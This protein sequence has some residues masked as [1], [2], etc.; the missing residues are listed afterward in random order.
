M[1]KYKPEGMLIKEYSNLEYISTKAGLERAL[2]C[3]VILEAEAV[4]CDQSMNLFVSLGDRVR[5]IIPRDE[6]EYNKS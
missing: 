6:V 4:L 3:G 1:N 2:E 5:G